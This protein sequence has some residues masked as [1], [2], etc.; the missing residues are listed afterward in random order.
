MSQHIQSVQSGTNSALNHSSLTGHLLAVANAVCRQPLKPA[1]MLLSP[2]GAWIYPLVPTLPAIAVNC[3]LCT[4]ASL[5][6]Y[7][8][9]QYDMEETLGAGLDRCIHMPTVLAIHDTVHV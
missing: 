7:A 5:A 1:S 8:V 9:F 4:L 6:E 2:R 3:D